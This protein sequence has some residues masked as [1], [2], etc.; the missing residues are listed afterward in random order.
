[1]RLILSSFGILVRLILLGSQSKDIHSHSGPSNCV[2]VLADSHLPQCSL[3]IR[4][5]SRI[6][7]HLFQRTNCLL[8]IILLYSYIVLLF[9]IVH[10]KRYSNYLHKLSPFLFP[11]NRTSDY[12]VSFSRGGLFACQELTLWAYAILPQHPR[13]YTHKFSCCPYYSIITFIA[14]SKPVILSAIL[15]LCRTLL[16]LKVVGQFSCRM[17]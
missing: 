7:C 4:L 17:L 8:H 15:P 12:A 2:G 5:Y 3:Q 11:A 6:R 16:S 10:Q 14:H 1:M 9:Q 13:R